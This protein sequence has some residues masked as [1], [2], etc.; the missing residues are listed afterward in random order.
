MEYP[1]RKI[2]EET[3]YYAFQYSADENGK[4]W[5]SSQTQ[6]VGWADSESRVELR[7]PRLVLPHRFA[8]FW[9]DYK[10]PFHVVNDVDDFV[11]W[12]LY[13]G[14]ALIKKSV[15]EELFSEQLEPDPCV[16]TGYVGFTS[17]QALPSTLFRPAPTP[18]LRM[19]VLKRDSYRCRICGRRPEGHVDIELHVHHIRPHGKRGPTH[20]D[21]LITL[22][23]TCHRGLDPHYEWA[24]YGLL[25]APDSNADTKASARRK[26]LEGVKAYRAATQRMLEQLGAHG[27]V[28]SSAGPKTKGVTL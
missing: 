7:A 17:R 23:D 4:V 28:S 15:A 18:K 5:L 11:R 24:L 19:S 22:C 3:D 27:D 8:Q 25:K 20:Q 14:H 10:M 26:Y 13:G 1:K 21:N 6:W 12:F 2:Q 16:Q 9:I